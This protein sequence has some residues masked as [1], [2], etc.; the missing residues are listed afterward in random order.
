[1]KKDLLATGQVVENEKVDS[2]HRIINM[3]E[4]QHDSSVT[5]DKGGSQAIN[6][7]DLIIGLSPCTGR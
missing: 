3:D 1:V 5:D 7:F 4:T 6:K 2:K